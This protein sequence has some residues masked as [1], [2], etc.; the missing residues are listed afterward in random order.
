[1]RSVFRKAVFA[2]L[3]VSLAASSLVLP[4]CGGES[5]ETQNGSKDRYSYWKGD[6]PNTYYRLDIGGNRGLQVT[7][8]PFMRLEY[9][10]VSGVPLMCEFGLSEAT[11]SFVPGHDIVAGEPTLDASV[12]SY[13]D[14]LDVKSPVDL[15]VSWGS[16]TSHEELSG[17]GFEFWCRRTKWEEWHFAMT[18]DGMEGE[19]SNTDNYSYLGG[20]SDLKAMKLLRNFNASD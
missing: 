20:E 17:G 5:S 9:D 2:L 15:L 16:V 13:A 8:K 7:G 11:Q 18:F 10:P 3:A 14:R 1:M 6:I 19:V 12:I 4:A